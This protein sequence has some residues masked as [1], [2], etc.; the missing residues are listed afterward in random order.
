MADCRLQGGTVHHIARLPNLKKIRTFQWIW[1]TQL[2][3]NRLVNAQRQGLMALGQVEISEDGSL[4]HLQGYGL[5]RVFKIVA[6][7]GDIQ[8]WV[9]NDLQMSELIRIKYANYA[10]TIE[11]YHRG[12]KQFCNMERAQRNH[13]GLALRAFLRL[14]I[15]CYHKGS[16]VLR[17]RHRSLEKQCEVIWTNRSTPLIQ[18]RNS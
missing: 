14:E 5:I 7:D 12:I 1:L 8:Y 9:T 10:W 4:V 2:K 17:P 11:D 13:V 3:E 15:H 18:L 16:V 6:T